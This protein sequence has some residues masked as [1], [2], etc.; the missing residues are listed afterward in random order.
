MSFVSIASASLAPRRESHALR[1]PVLN[2]QITQEVT[3]VLE[4]AGEGEIASEFLV[5]E[6]TEVLHNG[7]PCKYRDIPPSASIVRMEVDTDKKT[8]LKIH[9]RS[10]K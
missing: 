2:R 10:R 9:F 8:V 1:E 6:G 4:P 7:K 5:T 3:W